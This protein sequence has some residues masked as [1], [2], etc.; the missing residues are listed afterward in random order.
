MNNVLNIV[1]IYF[2]V[3]YFFGDQFL[4]LQKKGYNLHLVCSPS[5]F[6]QSYAQQQ[7]IQYAEIPIIR[8]ITPY[9]D[10]ISLIKICRYIKKNK[11]EIVVG[12]TPK[13]ALLAMLAGII[14]R[15]PKRIYF[16]HGFIN[17]A[18]G[19]VSRIILW[20][21]RFVSYCATKIVCVSPSLI[22][23]SIDMRLNPPS[24]Q[25]LLG[26]GTCGGIDTVRKFNPDVINGDDKKRL[27]QQLGIHEDA[28]V[29]GYCGRLVKDKGIGELVE[30]FNLL[31]TKYPDKK[32]RLLL[33]GMFDERD[34][35]SK[36]IKDAIN[37][38]RD[39]IYTGYVKDKIE[40]Y[41]TL[42]TLFILPSYREGFGM[43]VIEAS[44]M[45]LPVLTT[46]SLGCVDSIIE[47]E[48]GYYVDINPESISAGVERYFDIKLRDE[49]GSV[50]REFVVS[51][52]DNLI[53]WDEIE[54]LYN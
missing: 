38:D 28:F 52:F 40:Y 14:M 41:Y 22:Q 13:G 27:K 46:R 42:M 33:V 44:A 36:D 35:L 4:Y 51:N 24:K 26:K 3:P 30:G 5:E 20:E 18:K 12:H 32:L 54:K 49:I 29:I 53:L 25:V 21:E 39:I 23:L 9:Q 8:K 1:N 45:C 6:L 31:R 19:L 16:R 43:S 2:S 7:R 17:T 34:V 11:I 48:T 15:I 50:G 10:L 37:E 47:G